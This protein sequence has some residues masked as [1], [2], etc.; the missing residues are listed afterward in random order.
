MKLTEISIINYRSIICISDAKVSKFQAIIGEN[1]SGKS[2]ILSAI[3]V[4]LSAGSGG[5]KQEDFNDPENTIVIKC[6]FSVISPHLKKI[7]KPYLINDELIL[8]KHIWLEDDSKSGKQKIENQFHGY[9][10]EPSSWFL[11]IK[12]IKLENTGRPKWKEIVDTN[13]L[14]D[15]FIE[16]TKCTQAIFEKALARYL[17]ENEVEYDEPDLRETQA[18]GLKSNVVASL[19]KFYLLKAV[20]D[21]SDEIDKRATNSTFRKLMGDLAD[22]IIKKD[23]RYEKIEGALNTI[24]DLLNEKAEG[25]RE[26]E[27]RLESLKTIEDKLKEILCGLMPSVEKVSLRVVAEDIKSIFS[28]GIALT[29]DDGTDTDVLLKGHG[30]Q[31]C[32]VFSLIQALILNERN[33][34]IEEEETEVETPSIILAIEEP[35]LYI[36]PQLGKVFYDVLAVFSNSDQVIY[37]THSPR[38]I[39]VYE[40]ENIALIQK[41]KRSGTIIFNCDTSAFDGLT[42]KKIFKGL[43]QLNSDINELFFAKKVI[44]VEGPEDKVAITETLK[45]QGKLKNRSEELDITVIVAGGKSAIP[46]FTRVMNAFSIAFTVL[47]DLDITE[48]MPQPDKDT[49]KKTNDSIKELA[50]ESKIVTFPVKL[51]NSLGVDKGHFKDQYEAL[52]FFTDHDN[53]N[54]ELEGIVTELV[55]K[56]G[57]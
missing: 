4:F 52:R 22:R 26:K 1:N 46:F 19:P 55:E 47:H 16:D 21:Y 42:D 36:H 34:L 56:F 15:Y 13:G 49:N 31:R 6:K 40:Y 53:I 11:S 12:K 23:P 25:N 20:T 37:S 44:L 18:L 17:L 51:E 29:I 14:P 30:L 24:K 7:W 33:K 5:V 48:E 50:G 39:D 28:R 57:A 43:T 32:I 41:T 10:A 38:F 27:D 35:E 9:Q 8:E 2:N 3:D 54:A 45:K